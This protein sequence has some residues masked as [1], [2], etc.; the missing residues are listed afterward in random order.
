MA[1]LVAHDVG[2]PVFVAC[3]L[4]PGHHG[5]LDNSSTASSLRVCAD[6]DLYPCFFDD[7]AGARAWLLHQMSLDAKP[8]AAKK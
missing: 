2:H 4:D 1:P 7:E 8:R 3:V 5:V 6:Y